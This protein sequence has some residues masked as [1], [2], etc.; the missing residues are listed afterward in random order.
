MNYE[1]VNFRFFLVDLSWNAP[2][3]TYISPY[4]PIYTA[5]IDTYSAAPNGWAAVF[6]ANLP[7]VLECHR[8]YWY[9]SEQA[10][11]QW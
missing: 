11:I 3:S 6:L 10:D 4:E 1:G 7:A 9:R 5:Q 8:L 2:V